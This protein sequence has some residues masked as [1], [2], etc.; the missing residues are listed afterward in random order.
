MP[1]LHTRIHILR[2]VIRLFP[3]VCLFPEIHLVRRQQKTFLMG[4]LPEGFARKTVANWIHAAED[5]YLTILSVL[6]AEC[7]GALRISNGADD[8]GDYKL[9]S[10]DDVKALA[11]EGVSK[12]TELITEAHLSL[13]GDWKGGIIL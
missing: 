6:G 3:S 12:S 7:L 13:T 11:K 5:D 1:G 9:L 4:L 2:Q 8:T 10:I